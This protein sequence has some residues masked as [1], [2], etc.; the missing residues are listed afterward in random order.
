MLVCLSFPV[1]LSV[2]LGS[3]ALLLSLPAFHFTCWHVCDLRYVDKKRVRVCVIYDKLRK[4][5]CV[6]VSCV[7]DVLVAIWSRHVALAMR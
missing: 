2:V 4:S 1:L 3:M 5:V 6:C 7:F